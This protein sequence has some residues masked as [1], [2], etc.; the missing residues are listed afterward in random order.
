[1]PII[2]CMVSEEAIDAVIQAVESIRPKLNLQAQPPVMNLSPAKA[3]HSVGETLAPVLC[4][5]SQWGN[6]KRRL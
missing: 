4:V 5:G 3:K 1:M 6:S 2:G